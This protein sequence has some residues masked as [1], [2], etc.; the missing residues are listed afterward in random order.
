MAKEDWEPVYDRAG[1]IMTEL[2]KT[3]K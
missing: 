2:N 3:A 1:Q